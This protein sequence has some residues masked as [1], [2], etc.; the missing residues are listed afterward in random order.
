MCLILFSYQQH[1][2]YPLVVIANRDE[3]YQRPTLQAHWWKDEPHI[4]AGKDVQAGGSWM[5]VNR[6]GRFAAL[7]NIREPQN[8]KSD[9]PSRGHL[10]TDYLREQAR[11]S[12]EGYMGKISEKGQA[13]NGFN[14]LVGGPEE[15]WWYANRVEAPQQLEPGLYGL[16]NALLDTPWPKVE[17]GKAQLQQLLGNGE[18]FSHEQALFSL[19][20]PE[21]APDEQLPQTGVPLEW[22]RKL[23]AM[24][25]EM[26]KY[27][28]RCSTIVSYGADGRLT[29]TERS[30]VPDRE[31]VNMNFT[32]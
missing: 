30:Y 29:F 17:K 10:V 20:N 32:L 25:I 3:F 18:A 12:A 11:E 4:L 21:L 14:L 22:E 24:F 2:D 19:K 16:S 6:K 13:Y 7:T 31:D 1:P 23:S 8:I 5:G 9:A 26:E 15:L 28:T 27:G